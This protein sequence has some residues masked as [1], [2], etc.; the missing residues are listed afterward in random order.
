[1][2]EGYGRVWLYTILLLMQIFLS[3]YV[4]IGPYIYLCCLPLLVI[5]LPI[6]QNT[7]ISM[8]LAFL[9][10]LIVDLLGDGIPGLNAAAAVALAAVRKPLFWAFFNKNNI[11]RGDLPSIQEAGIFRH[12]NFLAASLAVFF[13]VYIGLDSAGMESILTTVLR[14]VLSIAANLVLLVVLDYFMLNA[15][16]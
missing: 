13:I 14:F 11:D 1:M 3:D 9:A 10:G 16:R 6:E 12:I 8:G 15:H 5:L 4:N 7:S 2:K